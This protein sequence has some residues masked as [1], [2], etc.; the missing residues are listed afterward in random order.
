MK[1]LL[2]VALL[3]GFSATYAAHPLW[4]GATSDNWHDA[5][6]WS[7]GFVPS[8]TGDYAV[9]NSMGAT[10]LSPMITDI[11]VLDTLNFRD[12]APSYNLQIQGLGAGLNFVGE[13][14][15]NESGKTQTLTVGGTAALGVSGPD[16]ANFADYRLNFFNSSSSGNATLVAA[17]GGIITFQGNS[18]AGTSAIQVQSGGGLYFIGDIDSPSASGAQVTVEAGGKMEIQ[19]IYQLNIGSIAGGGTFNLGDAILSVVGDFSTTVSGTI[20]GSSTKGGLRIDGPGTLTLT[21][22]N[23]YLGLT[24]VGTG[25]LKVTAGGDITQTSNLSIYNGGKLVVDGSDGGARVTVATDGG[26]SVGDYRGAGTL[27]LINGGTLDSSQGSIGINST[28]EVVVDG[29]DSA[30]TMTGDIRVGGEGAKG[31]LN[32]LNGGKVTSGGATFGSAG[33]EMGAVGQVTVSGTGSNWTINEGYVFLG[34]S[35]ATSSLEIK[36]GAKVE[37]RGSN[38]FY[39]GNG[40]VTVDGESSTFSAADAI[41]SLGSAGGNGVLKVSNGAAATLG[42]LYIGNFGNGTVTV[43]GEN[44][45]VQVSGD[46]FVGYGSGYGGG[47]TLN[48]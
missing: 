32:I 29:T 15:L 28:A 11:I 16:V 36:D 14:I 10:R 41:L 46:V 8:I 30:W 26:V 42:G 2:L 7:T 18:N 17:D 35:N 4:Q 3:G 45:L 43:D 47:G 34:G 23:T 21:G 19:N 24:D 39:A 48:L 1:R 12:D 6:N 33:M 13:G 5:A 40:T 37:H 38:G 22:E 25:T 44:S 27:S 9:F 31:T 20:T